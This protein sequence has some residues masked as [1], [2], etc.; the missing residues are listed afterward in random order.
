MASA[1]R[2]LS[3]V[4]NISGSVLTDSLVEK[5]QAIATRHNGEV[6]LHGRLFAQWLHFAFPHECPFPAILESADALSTSQWSSDAYSASSEERTTHLLSADVSTPS[7]DGAVEDHWI[8]HEVLPA[9]GDE[10]ARWISLATGVRGT[11]QLVAILLGLRS[12]LVAWK[13]AVGVGN[14]KGKKSGCKKDDDFALGFSV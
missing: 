2:I 3:L 6:P 9:H 4:R 13:G 14:E 5:L 10:P 1:E 8:D 11:V 12:M 7:G